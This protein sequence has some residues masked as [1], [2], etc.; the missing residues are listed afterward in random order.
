MASFEA[1]LHL[2]GE[3]EFYVLRSCSYSFSQQIT[4]GGMPGSEVYG[5]TIHF[6]W[7]DDAKE[8]DTTLIEWAIKANSKKTGTVKFMH[9]EEEDQTYREVKFEEGYCV[10][11]TEN[12]AGRGQGLICNFSI[13]APKME[14]GDIPYENKRWNTKRS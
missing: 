9:L 4:A 6:E 13:A 8:S 1:Q 7:E 12:F 2:D 14:I 10:Q 11:F 5:G 3:S